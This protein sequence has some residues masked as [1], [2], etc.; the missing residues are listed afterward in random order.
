MIFHTMTHGFTMAFT[1]ISKI[2][3]TVR[4]KSN[5][6]P[7]NTLLVITWMLARVK[8]KSFLSPEAQGV[9]AYTRFQWSK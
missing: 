8:V 1:N 2:K 5:L 3:A 7:D 4:T 6:H 9:D